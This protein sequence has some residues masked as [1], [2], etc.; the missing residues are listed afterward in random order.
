M[1]SVRTLEQ[2]TLSEHWCISPLPAL[3]YNPLPKHWGTFLYQ[4]IGVLVLYTV[5]IGLLVLYQHIDIP[6]IRTLV[7]CPLSEHW[8]IFL[9]QN[10]GVITL[11][12]HR[13]IS[14]LPQT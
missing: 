5:K 14:P 12:K 4:N 6:S 9:Y 3:V 2:I 10:I 13:C 7:L 1:P 8:C 11:S